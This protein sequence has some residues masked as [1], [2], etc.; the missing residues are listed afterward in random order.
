MAGE[1]VVQ[2]DVVQEEVVEIEEMPQ[3]SFSKLS[4]GDTKK[5]VLMQVK[6]GEA[7]QKN[8][9]AAMM[10]AFDGLQKYLA[11]VV[12]SIPREWLSE[13]APDG[14]VWS[15]PNSFDWVGGDRFQ[16]LLGAMS[17]AQTARKKT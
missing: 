17:Q 1:N 6:V 11:R 14:L 15:D 3:F 12:V 10:E 4:W 16:D 13:D 9:A 5:L 8:D 2:E 7:S